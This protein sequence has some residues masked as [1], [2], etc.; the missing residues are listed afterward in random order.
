MTHPVR[1]N[2]N[3][4][5]LRNL[6]QPPFESEGYPIILTSVHQGDRRLQPATQS[7]RHQWAGLSLL[8]SGATAF[9]GLR[10]FPMT[11]TVTTSQ[12]PQPPTV[13]HVAPPDAKVRIPAPPISK[14]DPF[15]TS[16]IGVPPQIFQLEGAGQPN[17][18]IALHRLP[19]GKDGSNRPDCVGERNALQ[20]DFI[21]N[22]I[23]Q[24]AGRAFMLCPIGQ[25]P[26][27]LATKA[28]DCLGQIPK[29]RWD[30]PLSYLGG[31][32]NTTLRRD[33]KALE[34]SGI[35]TI[36]LIEVGGRIGDVGV[37]EGE[38]TFFN[39]TVDAGKRRV[40][41]EMD[42]VLPHQ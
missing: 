29:Q 26:S 40:K 24:T 42:R 23:G 27:D 2:Y 14:N 9:L 21:T 32:L 34:Q 35:T 12:A 3:S 17:V 18:T 33:N 38:P 20:Q 10:F 25:S 15:C 31:A 36:H 37:A 4:P 41:A 8:M 6:S 16:P 1:P 30:S 19:L 39:P 13:I 7:R 5:P 28:L 11:P 22:G